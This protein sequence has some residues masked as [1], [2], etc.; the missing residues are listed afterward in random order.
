[1]KDAVVAKVAAQ[2]SDFY[3]DALQAA[4]TSSVKQQ[5]E[6]VSLLCT[7]KTFIAF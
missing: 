4:N 6:K 1:M 2:A 7:S 5:F 3:K